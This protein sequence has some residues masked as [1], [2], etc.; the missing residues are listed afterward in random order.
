VVVKGLVASFPS[1]AAYKVIR[2]DKIAVL[3]AETS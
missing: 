1:I 3:S 2:L